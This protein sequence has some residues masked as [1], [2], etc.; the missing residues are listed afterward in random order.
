M[1]Q[2]QLGIKS[3]TFSTTVV[4]QL[5]RMLPGCLQSEVFWHVWTGRGS[6]KDPGPFGRD[7]ISLLPCQHLGTHP[8]NLEKRWPWRTVNSLSFRITF[9]RTLK[10]GKRNCSP[11]TGEGLVKS[12]SV[13]KWLSLARYRC[14][15]SSQK[16]LRSGLWKTTPTTSSDELFCKRPHLCLKYISCWNDM[17]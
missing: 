5:V 2:E 13:V 10:S 3:S 7:Y 17:L 4:Q 1:A 12:G 11:P 9:Q 6:K 14:S 15:S 16:C 8:E